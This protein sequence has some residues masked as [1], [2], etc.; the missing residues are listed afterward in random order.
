MIGSARFR[1]VCRSQGLWGTYGLWRTYGPSVFSPALQ[2]CDG[3]YLVSLREH[4][5]GLHLQSHIVFLRE[6]LEVARQGQ[7]VTGNIDQPGYL[8]RSQR[9][10]RLWTQAFTG[11]VHD[12]QV[13]PR[14][15]C[16]RLSELLRRVPG[17]EAGVV[18]PVAA[19]IFLGHVDC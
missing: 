18:I 2:Q 13:D 12:D 16:R 9:R 10:E 5:K 1:A 3:L 4:I 14:Q 7:R 17:K 11:W 19:R 15:G 6:A 8:D